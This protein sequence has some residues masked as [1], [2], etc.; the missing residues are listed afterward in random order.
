MFWFNR[1]GVVGRDIPLNGAR[2]PFE[3]VRDEH[4]VLLGIARREDIGALDGLVEVAKDVVDDNNSLGGVGR[5]G[6][7]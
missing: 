2:L 3:P 5:A 6:C 4:L 1:R 7:V